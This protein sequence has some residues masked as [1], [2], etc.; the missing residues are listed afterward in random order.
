M[1]CDS[2]I[3]REAVK[4]AHELNIYSI[5]H[6]IYVFNTLFDTEPKCTKWLL[7]SKTTFLTR[8]TDELSNFITHKHEN[9]HSFVTV[10]KP[11]SK[12]NSAAAGKLHCA[13]STLAS[14]TSN[15]LLVLLT[16]SHIN[17]KSQIFRYSCPQMRVTH[18]NFNTI[19]SIPQWIP[20]VTPVLQ[21]TTVTEKWTTLP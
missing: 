17:G 5:M 9:W 21:S 6:K 10:Q 15:Y 1:V 3:C 16:I 2:R 11:Y 19:W 13:T 7:I 14:H 12:Y 20:Y 18:Q 4:S 8:H